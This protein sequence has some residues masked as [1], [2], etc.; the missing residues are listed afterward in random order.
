[1]QI[2]RPWIWLS[3]FFLQNNGLLPVASLG[4]HQVHP[5]VLDALLVSGVGDVTGLLGQVQRPHAALSR[6]I[7]HQKNEFH[8][9]NARRLGNVRGGCTGK[10]AMKLSKIVDGK[11]RSMA[12]LDTKHME[13]VKIGYKRYGNLKG[14]GVGR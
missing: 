12:E 2:P 7:Q 14:Q 4:T 8:I 10:G 1:M 9:R 3:A 13:I 11:V 5:R 6:F